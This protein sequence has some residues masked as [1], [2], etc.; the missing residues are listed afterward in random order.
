MN[1]ESI[2]GVLL[3]AAFLTHCAWISF[4]VYAVEK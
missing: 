3:V 2:T 1:T 4:V